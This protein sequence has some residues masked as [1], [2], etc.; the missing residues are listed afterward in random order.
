MRNIS[1]KKS[2]E[3]ISPEEIEQVESELG[4]K[5]PSSLKSF[6]ADKNGGVPEPNCWIR[7]DSDPLCVHRFLPMKYPGGNLTIEALYK[8][9]LEKDFLPDDL[10]P[11]AVD[12]GSNFFCVDSEDRVF[13]YAM[14]SWR[15]KL[16]SDENKARARK[17][18]ANSFDEFIGGLTTEPEDY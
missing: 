10:I 9:G 1:L 7:D 13:F 3:S 6:Y 8:R 15:D 14:D 12:S 11:F 17:F 16:S 4:V 2:G 18:L 5:L